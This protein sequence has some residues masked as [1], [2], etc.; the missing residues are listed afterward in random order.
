MR[1]GVFFM[2]QL[3][4]RARSAPYVENVGEWLAL[5]LGEHLRIVI[6]AHLVDAGMARFAHLR[7][8][9]EFPD[10]KLLVFVSGACHGASLVASRTIKVSLI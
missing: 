4:D 5:Q 8:L 2:Q 3:N 6:L 9:R 1:V 7:G 10:G